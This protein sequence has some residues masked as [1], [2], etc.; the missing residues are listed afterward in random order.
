MDRIIVAFRGEETR[1]RILRLLALE[2]LP[3]SP[4]EF[5]ATLRLLLDRAPAPRPASRRNEADQALIRR[6]KALLMDVNRMSEEDAHRFLRRRAMDGGMKL[7]EAAR[8]IIESYG[9]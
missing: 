4:P 6:A 5:A 3:V 9:M 1:I 2:G 8:R 7:E